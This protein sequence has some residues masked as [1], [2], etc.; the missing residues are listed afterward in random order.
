[1]KMSRTTGKPVH[2]VENV[3]GK[4]LEDPKKRA[5]MKGRPFDLI[6]HEDHIDYK[7]EGNLIVKRI[8]PKVYVWRGEIGKGHTMREICGAVWNHKGV[9]IRY[10]SGGEVNAKTLAA[11]LHTPTMI[12]GYLHPRQEY[13]G[14]YAA[15]VIDYRKNPWRIYEEFLKDQDDRIKDI[16]SF[17]DKKFEDIQLESWIPSPIRDFIL[18]VRDPENHVPDTEFGEMIRLLLG[19]SDRVHGRRPDKHFWAYVKDYE[20]FGPEIAALNLAAFDGAKQLV[21]TC[22]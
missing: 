19:Y 15:E 3:V 18:T 21:K 5:A 8:G 17:S 14:E 10:F 6:F 22:N 12:W 20:K 9:T 13:F 2:C 7:W 1:M 16:E 4:W 11:L